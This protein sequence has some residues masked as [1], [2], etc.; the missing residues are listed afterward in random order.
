VK[1]YVPT[2][3]RKD[4][5]AQPRRPI[6]YAVGREVGPGEFAMWAGPW[7]IEETAL[8]I[9]GNCSQDRVI[10]YNSDGTEVVL[11]TWHTDRWTSVD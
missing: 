2:L 3:L 1:V 5:L 11:W 9:V 7:P 8:E 4:K 6:R 10:R